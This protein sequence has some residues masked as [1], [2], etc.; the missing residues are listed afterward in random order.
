M[1]TKKSSLLSQDQLASPDG[2]IAY[3]IRLSPRRRRVAVQ[4]H[5][6]GR[7]LVAAPLGAHLDELRRFV[8][9]RREWIIKHQTRFKALGV[10]QRP[11]HDGA[12]LPLLDDA[13]RLRIVISQNRETIAR[14]GAELALSV[15]DERR[16][17][18][19][20]EGWY[21]EQ[22]FIFATARTTHYTCL[23]GRSPSRIVVRGQK[24]RWG[25]C[26]PSGT[27]SINWRLLLA[28]SPVFDYV[29]VHELCHLLH[30]DHSPRFWAAVGRVL[31]DYGL[32]RRQLH[33]IG[34]SL[35]L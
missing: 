27:I 30:P 20:L 23:V 3:A 8:H 17:R 16:V 2:M 33:A 5:P 13:V 28:P 21:R 15:R 25:S 26:S 7:V 34:H 4:V 19:L 24:T 22:A 9:E 14:H 35:V 10:V 32:Q 29:L 11:L 1:P 18:P 6:D 31:P 12:S